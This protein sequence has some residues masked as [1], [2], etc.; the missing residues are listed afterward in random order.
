MDTA[1]WDRAEVVNE[2]IPFQRIALLLQGGGAL[3]AY[4]AGVYQALA[5]AHVAPN[6]VAGISIGAINAAIIAGNPREARVEKLRQFWEKVTAQPTDPLI[7]WFAHAV[8]GDF[9]RRILNEL[10][11]FRTMFAGAPAFFT[12]RPVNPWLLQPGAP[13]ASSYYDTTPLIATLESLVDFDRIN[14]REM[15][16]SVGAVNVRTGNFVYFDNHRDHIDVRHV[17][18]SGALPPGFGAIEID[19]QCY[20]DGGLVSNTPLTWVLNAEPRENTLAFQVDLWSSRGPV[21]GTMGDVLVRQKEIQYSSRTRAETDHFKSLQRKRFAA[22]ALIEKLPPELAQTKE[23]EYLA[24]VADRCKYNIIELVYR[25]KNYEDQSKDYEF[26]RL[27]ME[28]HWRSGYNDAAR[29]LRQ[30]EVFQLPRNSEGV[31]TFDIAY[32]GKD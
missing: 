8:E 23:A 21:P 10:S 18:A 9:T 26:S 31:F 1:T 20:W 19:G 32:D 27:T 17:M 5:E 14:S 12:P 6:W 11:A 4:Q 16:F 28:D 29:T 7:A 15:H 3:G 25:S 24:Q 22:A 2:R 30:K 13:G